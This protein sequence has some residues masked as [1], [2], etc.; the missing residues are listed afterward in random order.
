MGSGS[1]DSNG[2]DRKSLGEVG[3]AI[4]ANH[5]SLAN[6]EY[7]YLRLG[8]AGSWPGVVSSRTGDTTVFASLSKGARD[9]V[10]QGFLFPNLSD[11]CE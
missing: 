1:I 8:R 2:F 7:R 6:R 10:V 4:T 3:S 9:W 11:A 5:P